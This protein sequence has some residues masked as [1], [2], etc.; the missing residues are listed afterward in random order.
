MATLNEPA[1]KAFA[2]VNRLCGEW[3]SRW[4]SGSLF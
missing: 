3:I 4:I 2:S 1:M